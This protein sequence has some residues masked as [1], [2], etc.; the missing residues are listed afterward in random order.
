[1]GVR[2]VPVNNVVLPQVVS[3]NNVYRAIVC[4]QGA[5]IEGDFAGQD[6]EDTPGNIGQKATVAG[7]TMITREPMDRLQEIIAQSWK[8]IGGFC[9]PSDTTANPSVIPTANNSAFKRAIVI[10]SL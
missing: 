8:W 1:M 2:F 4:G 3:G 7:I 9:V 10:E 5:L 6:A